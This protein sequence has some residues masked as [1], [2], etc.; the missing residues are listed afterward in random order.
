MRTSASPTLWRFSRS[1]RFRNEAA[2]L[3][4]CASLLILLRRTRRQDAEHPREVLRNPGTSPLR[5]KR[6]LAG[7]SYRG[8]SARPAWRHPQVDII[9]LSALSAT[10]D[11]LYLV[12]GT[13]LN[14]RVTYVNGRFT[15]EGR[16]RGQART[17][18]VERDDVRRLELN[19]VTDNPREAPGEQYFMKKIPSSQAK[20]TKADTIKFKDGKF[21]YGTLTAIEQ[22]NVTIVSTAKGATNCTTRGT[23]ACCAKLKKVRVG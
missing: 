17:R 19:S 7:R 5:R 15:I 3:G 13:N 4:S 21:G 12:N 11:T 22:D 23:A 10:A 8:R 14:G 9:V 20:P 1:R 6:R 18:E 16:F 2:A